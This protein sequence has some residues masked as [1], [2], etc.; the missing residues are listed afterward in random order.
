MLRT[1]LSVLCSGFSRLRF[2]LFSLVRLRR[3]S[4]LVSCGSGDWDDGTASVSG[5]QGIGEPPTHAKS[6]LEASNQ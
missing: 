6:S 1:L 5:T 4:F 3:L 2:L